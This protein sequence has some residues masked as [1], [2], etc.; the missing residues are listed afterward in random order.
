MPAPW[1]WLCEACRIFAICEAHETADLL[2]SLQCARD[3]LRDWCG[4]CAKTSGDFTISDLR[5]DPLRCGIGV[6]ECAKTADFLRLLIFARD[7]LRDWRGRCAKTADFLQFLICAR[8]PLRGLAWSTER[9]AKNATCLVGKAGL[10]VCPVVCAP[11]LESEQ[12][13]LE[14]CLVA[15]ASK[16]WKGST[17]TALA[18]KSQLSSTKVAHEVQFRSSG[19]KIATSTEALREVHFQKGSGWKIATFPYESVARTTLSEGLGWQMAALSYESITQSILRSDPDRQLESRERLLCCGL[20]CTS[21]ARAELLR[22]NVP[23]T[24]RA[25]CTELLGREL[26]QSSQHRS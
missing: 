17:F 24:R 8:D 11:G 5:A 15:V 9:N 18:K 12:P 26:A 10:K 21:A 22:T 13:W 19:W 16:S 4:R 23:R 14:S 20:R 2:R 3:P 6:V 7:L 1:D 25:T